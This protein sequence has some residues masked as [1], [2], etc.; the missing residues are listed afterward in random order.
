MLEYQAQSSTWC[1]K[2]ERFHLNPL[3]ILRLL[4]TMQNTHFYSSSLLSVARLNRLD[5]AAIT[6]GAED[7][8]TPA[9]KAKVDERWPILEVLTGSIWLENRPRTW[10]RKN[11]EMFLEYNSTYIA[12]KIISTLTYRPLHNSY[13][14]FGLNGPKMNGQPQ[15]ELCMGPED[16]TSKWSDNCVF[17]FK[18]MSVRLKSSRNDLLGKWE[19][20]IFW[21]CLN[22]CTGMWCGHFKV[23]INENIVNSNLHTSL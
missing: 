12:C 16:S 9:S 13:R 20:S 22:I 23:L 6:E 5:V 17:G 3:H 2:L 15:H 4:V 21:A 14:R 19:K 1:P 11:G 8:A 18:L 10:H 7:P